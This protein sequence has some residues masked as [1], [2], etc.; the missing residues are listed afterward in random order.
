MLKSNIHGHGTIKKLRTGAVVSVL[1]T[2]MLV[3]GVVSAEEVVTGTE[4]TSVEVVAETKV[5][6]AQ[7]SEAKAEADQANQAVTEQEAVVGGLEETIATGESKVSDLN[8]QIEEANK[9]T[10][11]VVADAKTDADTKSDALA[12]A[13]DTVETATNSANA[14]AEAVATQENVVSDA[15]A[16]AQKTASAVADA[17]KKVAD[18]SG[19]TDTTQL[20]KDVETLTETVAKDTTDLA[21]AKQALESAQL[22]ETNKS[23][24]ISTQEGVVAS[25]EADV[26]ST[27]TALVDATKAKSDAEKEVSTTKSALDTAKAGTT[28]T[29]GTTE[30]PYFKDSVGYAPELSDAYLDAIKA[31]YEGT[32]TTSGVRSAIN[33][34]YTSEET[35]VSATTLRN[36]NSTGTRFVEGEFVPY[37]SEDT[38]STVI[39]DFNNLTTEQSKELSLYAATII[40]DLRAKFGTSKLAV[41]DTSVAL[42]VALMQ[43]EQ[44]FYTVNTWSGEKNTTTYT[45]PLSENL[46]SSETEIGVTGGTSTAVQGKLIPTFSSV[47]VNNLTMG[48]LKLLVYQGIVN[49]LMGSSESTTS[50][51]TYASAFSILGLDGTQNVALGVDLAHEYAQGKP[52]SFF[53][54]FVFTPVATNI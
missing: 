2:S 4:A 19:T 51:T 14:T 38:D 43:K 7:V 27:A 20:Q 31:L 49:S 5:T 16:N 37:G 3:G 11:K 36:Y 24:A 46:A 33:S 45:K 34:A 29:T 40:N 41:T 1:T 39:V 21:E 18:L 15:N 48:D 30:T 32:G 47:D 54:T 10:P 50:P 23:Q 44:Y 6:D 12:T 22:A 53:T 8:T 42:A 26:D 35:G 25:K 13:N 28:V 9:V 52:N 17:E